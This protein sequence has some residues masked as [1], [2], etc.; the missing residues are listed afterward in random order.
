MTEDFTGQGH[1][2]SIY[3]GTWVSGKQGQ[4]IRFAARGDYVSFWTS[5]FGIDTTNEYTLSFWTRL[6]SQTG[7]CTFIDRNYGQPINIGYASGGRLQAITSTDS[8]GGTQ[9]LY[10]KSAI[11]QGQWRHV[12]LS[13]K[14]GAFA[15]YV[16]GVLDTSRVVRGKPSMSTGS[17][18]YI[19]NP[20]YLSG[21]PVAAAYDEVRLY[22]R[23][24]LSVEVQSLFGEVPSGL[25][26]LPGT[27]HTPTR[28]M[29]V[30]P[31]PAQGN[32]IVE[33]LPWTDGCVISDVQGNIIPRVQY[34]NGY[35]YF[36]RP[37][38][39]GVYVIRDRQGAVLGRFTI[40]R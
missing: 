35:L 13:Y 36:E 22:N 16:N 39:N 38:G 27:A 5:K 2:G 25:S 34:Q 12:T 40:V 20:Y 9:Y 18:L 4:A 23:A 15:L 17:N 7:T 30:F 3:N 10:G 19:G 37:M 26:V 21:N 6:E 33:G 24:L 14:S 31:N 29:T 8:S 1:Q 32:C 11:P 28:T